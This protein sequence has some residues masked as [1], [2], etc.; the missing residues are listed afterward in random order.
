MKITKTQLKQII[1]EE[2]EAV[3]KEARASAPSPLTG[4]VHYGE[5]EQEPEQGDEADG[6]QDFWMYELNTALL[7]AMGDAGVGNTMMPSAFLK[8]L[9]P[10]LE[11][12]GVGDQAQKMVDHVQSNQDLYSPRAP[13]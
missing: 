12:Y 5:E 6:M 10:V 7:A 13:R 3:L 8:A 11:A 4:Q 1:K 9:L 2:L